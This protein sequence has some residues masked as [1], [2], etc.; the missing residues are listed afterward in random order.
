MFVYSVKTSKTKIMAVAFAVVAVVIS[1]VM[2][3]MNEKK[4]VL[5]NTA[6]NYKAENSAQR[7]AFISQFGWKISDEPVE[8]SEVIIP[9]DF[10]AGY[11]EY[12]AMN[13]AQGLDLEIYK[14][15]RAKRWT[16]DVLNYPGLENMNGTVQV[17]LLIYEGRVIGGDVCSLE[18]GGFIHGFEIPEGTEPQTTAPLMSADVVEKS[19]EENNY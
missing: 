18:Q 13:K 11:T 15:V 2:L 19:T 5:D 3:F 17:N 9:E 16:Y 8:I 6:I 10:D 1:I 12:A 14:G 4:P 7:T